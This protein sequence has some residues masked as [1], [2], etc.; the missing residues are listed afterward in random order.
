MIYFDIIILKLNASALYHSYMTIEG[1]KLVSKD[2]YIRNIEC[3]FS[4]NTEFQVLDKD[5]TLQCLNTVQ[6]YLNTLFNRVEILDDKSKTYAS[7]ICTNR[8]S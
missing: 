1:T 5:P 3:L 2:D 6:N 4:D 8:Q 7:K